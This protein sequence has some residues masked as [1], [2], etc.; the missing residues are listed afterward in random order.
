[1]AASDPHRLAAVDDHCMTGRESAEVRREPEHRGS[2]LLRA[3]H[4]ADGFLIDHS[5]PPSGVPPENLSIIGVSMM[6]GQI[7]LTLMP[8]AAYSSAADFVRPIS[9]CLAATYAA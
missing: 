7:A 8:C 2:N 1:M 5:G 9:P 6:P 3:A 4:P